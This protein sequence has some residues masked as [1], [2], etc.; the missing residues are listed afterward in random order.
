MGNGQTDGRPDGR[1]DGRTG[2][3]NPNRTLSSTVKNHKKCPSVIRNCKMTPT[4]PPGTSET[5]NDGK[6]GIY[7]NRCIYHTV[8]TYA[9]PKEA[10]CPKKLSG[11]RFLIPR[12]ILTSKLANVSRTFPR[13]DSRGP[14]KKSENW[15][16]YFTSGTQRCPMR[17]PVD[18]SSSYQNGNSGLQNQSLGCQA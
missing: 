17:C 7:W 2:G 4:R 16:R 18:R 8:T 6:L 15:C 1:A 3:R 5:Q 14:R 11:H 13:S 10:F 9:L 12:P